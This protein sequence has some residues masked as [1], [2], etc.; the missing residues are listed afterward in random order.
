MYPRFGACARARA[1]R[2]YVRHLRALAPA[3]ADAAATVQTARDPRTG[4]FFPSLCTL[5]VLAPRAG[6]TFL[7]QVLAFE[8]PLCRRRCG[9][10]TFCAAWKLIKS[11]RVSGEKKR[12]E[13]ERERVSEEDDDGLYRVCRRPVR[14]FGRGENRVWPQARARMGFFPGALMWKR[15]A[16]EWLR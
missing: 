14:R 3:S 4:F 8:G 12:T 9:S 1:A 7:R 5:Y 6:S 2:V 13:R 15:W 10:C 16:A 11:T